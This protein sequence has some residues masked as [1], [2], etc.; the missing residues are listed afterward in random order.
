AFDGTSAT[1]S[2]W[3][4]ADLVEEPTTSVRSLWVDPDQ[5]LWLGTE[6]GVV[7]REGT[8]LVPAG[9]SGT[10]T[11]L[12]G[13]AADNVLAIVSY[14]VHHFDG[15]S[16]TD[17]GLANVV[18]AWTGAANDAI[19]AESGGL[20][21]LWDG[22][23][24]TAG[25][26]LPG[27]ADDVWGSQTLGYVALVDG[28]LYSLEGSAWIGAGED[29]LLALW[30]PLEG[31]PFAIGSRGRAVRRESGQWVELP[32][33]LG[34]NLFNIGG[35][36]PNDVVATGVNDFG[37]YFDGTEW[38]PIR[39]PDGFDGFGVLAV[40]AKAVYLVRDDNVRILHRRDGTQ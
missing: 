38:T 16:W 2:G 6:D 34:T 9:L 12:Q 26:T 24:L 40:S 1:S 18:A 15:N 13:T 3:F 29:N 32:T 7:R 8:Q 21:W 36:G 5:T 17:L 28:D 20:V 27:D 25:P 35:S 11:F 39:F 31:P 22:S 14:E 19:L 33:G 4:W 37:A 23:Q 30:G 10:V